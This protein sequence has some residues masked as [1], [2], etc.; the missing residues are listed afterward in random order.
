MITRI[1][2]LILSI[3][4]LVMAV[5]NHVFHLGLVERLE[6]DIS[7]QDLFTLGECSGAWLMFGV[8]SVIMSADFLVSYLMKKA[9]NK[10]KE[11]GQKE[12]NGTD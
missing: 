10:G 7:T 2:G 6:D 8:F 4:I 1:V 3:V 12:E 9:R 11:T 5:F